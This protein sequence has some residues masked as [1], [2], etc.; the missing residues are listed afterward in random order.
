MES[1]SRLFDQYY[2]ASYSP[3]QTIFLNCDKTI[4]PVKTSGGKQN[5]TNELCWSTADAEIGLH[6]QTYWLHL[7]L[8]TTSK[9]TSH[10]ESALGAKSTAVA[11]DMRREN[12]RAPAGYRTDFCRVRRPIYVAEH[13]W[14]SQTFGGDPHWRL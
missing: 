3:I 9:T 11:C 8:E 13:N 10:D 7:Y 4:A 1:C 2:F 12:E 6:S 14:Q 5:T